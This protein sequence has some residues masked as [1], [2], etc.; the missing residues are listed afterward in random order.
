[1]L[2]REL[3]ENGAQRLPERTALIFRDQP[4]TFAQLSEQTR[5]LAAGYAALGVEAGDRVA[6]LLPNSPAFIMGYYAAAY[7]GAVSVPANP[8]LKPPELAYIWG[9]AGVKL[10]LTAEPLLPNVLEA[11]KELP[12]LHHIVCLTGASAPASTSTP[13]SPQSVPGLILFS[14]LLT[15]EPLSSA[16]LPSVQEEDC[17]VILYTSGTTGHPKGAMLSHRNLTRNIEQVLGRLQFTQE[18]R[19]LTVLPLF[20][21]FAGTVCMNLPMMVGASSV[22]LDSFSPGKV[23]E[24]VARHRVTVLPAVPA[25]FYALLQ[26]PPDPTLDLSSLRFLV[27]GGA[28]LPVAMLEA[29]E[30]RFGVPVIEGDGPTECSPVTS[31]NPLEGPRKPGS[32]G[33]PLPGVEIAIVDDEDRPLPTGEVGEIVVRGDNVMMGYLNQPEATRE[34]MR[35]GWYHTGDLGRL[36]EDGYLYIVDRKKDM[37]ITAGLNVYPREVEEVLITHPAVADVAVIG[38]PDA[39]RGEEV[40]AVVVC[41]EG[42]SQEG[43]DRELIRHCR[44]RLADYKVPRKVFFRDSLPRSSTGKVLKRLLKKEMEMQVG[45]QP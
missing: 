12:E 40:V 34:A 24:S 2:L 15:H 35:N 33:P 22:L 31:A 14:D 42:V 3:L 5:R 6:L 32:V 8:M 36:D 9:D 27:S 7:L 38:L 44:A 18:D 41:K 28:P 37:V 23:L 1:M 45:E 30:K 29:L 11:R 4:I 20:H 21:A 39:L 25:M 43:L 26:L 16:A 10:V 17:A 13:I 19:L